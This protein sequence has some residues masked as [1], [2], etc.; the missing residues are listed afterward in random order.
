[1]RLRAITKRSR[2]CVSEGGVAWTWPGPQPPWPHGPP[3]HRAAG[4]AEMAGPLA[5]SCPGF[6]PEPQGWG[7]PQQVWSFRVRIC[8]DFSKSVLGNPTSGIP[9]CPP[10]QAL[11]Q[12][13][14]GR[15]REGHSGGATPAC[16]PWGLLHP[17][18]GSVS[19]S[20]PTAPTSLPE[21]CSSPELKIEA[22][23]HWPE[24]DKGLPPLPNSV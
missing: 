22:P 11:G 12:V 17:S 24:T 14:A 6:R 2:H 18:L 19:C 5:S 1:M 7:Q 10:L 8:A 13:L 15:V 23:A 4:T 3:S 9:L 16:L 21:V 20:L